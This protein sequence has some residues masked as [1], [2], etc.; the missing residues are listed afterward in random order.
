MSITG[1]GEYTLQDG[2]WERVAVFDGEDRDIT[3]DAEFIDTL[4]H[5]WL[6]YYARNTVVMINGAERSFFTPGHGFDLGSPIVGSALGAQTW[7]S[8]HRRAG[9]L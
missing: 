6:M 1:H 2:K 7:L 4:G 3:P 9:I 5:V 8:G